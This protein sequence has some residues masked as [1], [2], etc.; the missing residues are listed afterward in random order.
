MCISG[1]CNCEAV[2]TI[3]INRW[4]GFCFC[5]W[6]R[7]HGN[8]IPFLIIP[9]RIFNTLGCECV[10]VYYMFG[11]TKSSASMSKRSACTTPAYYDLYTRSQPQPHS[12]HTQ[13]HFHF[14]TY[15]IIHSYS[16][17]QHTHLT[18]YVWKINIRFTGVRYAFTYISPHLTYGCFVTALY[19][20]HSFSP[21]IYIHE[22]RTTKATIELKQRM[23][24]NKTGDIL[25][26]SCRL[27]S[28]RVCLKFIFVPLGWS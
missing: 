22:K 10:C 4:H 7:W 25:Q 2:C 18:M 15:S 27:V 1:C 26:T 11:L 12:S 20:A 21:L 6:K 13:T 16:L 17:T 9:K 23:E 3:Y 24:H 8:Y 5:S 19:F 14:C 28:F